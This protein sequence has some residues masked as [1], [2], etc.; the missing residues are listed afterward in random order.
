MRIYVET[1]IRCTV[2]DLWRLT[3]VPEEHVSW[4]LRFTEIEYLQRPDENTS[5]QFL[6]VTRIGLGLTVRGKGE[7]VGQRNMPNGER[8]SALKFWSDDPMSLILE[9][10]GYWRYIPE[11]D[12]VRFLT[13]YDYKVRF[14]A[15]GRVFDAIVFRPLIGWATAWSFDR[16]RLWIEKRVDP[17]VAMQ[18]SLLHAI[19]R[20]SLAVVWVYQGAVPK[21]LAQH[22]DELIMVELGGF[23][24]ATAPLVVQTIGW[25]EILF[26]AAML[27][28]FHH[29]WPLFVTIAMMFGATL[30]V[31]MSS[32]QYLAAAFNPVTLN[33][34]MISTALTG[35]LASQ[36]LPS[37]RRC[38]RK[39]PKEW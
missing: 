10:A 8:M 3:Q 36:D 24:A 23:S 30:S 29:R 33:L 22:S 39:Q 26:G 16:L 21:L 7:T 25:I 37:A 27:F 32:P 2:D 17:S 20:F 19:A 4:D 9:G 15:F 5:Q 38:L 31:A 34:L 14:G 28:F 12:G 35:L 6:Y 1:R 18:R 11:D 13:A